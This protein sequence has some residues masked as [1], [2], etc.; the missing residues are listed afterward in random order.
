MPKLWND[1]IPAHKEAVRDA[2]LDAAAA[3]VAAHGLAG[4][5][6]SG[7]AT[8]TGIGRA[9]LYKYFPDVETILAAWHERQVTHHLAELSAIAARPAEPGARLAAVLEAY[10]VLSMGRSH[11]PAAANLH[12]GEPMQHAH[13]HLRGFVRDLIA[14]AAKAGA[15]RPDIAADELAGY[16]LATLEAAKGL[17]SK[18]AVGRLVTMVMDG[19]RARA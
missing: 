14:D 16:C 1:T 4:V 8:A 12:R 13:Q 5:T 10:G 9:T 3:L 19:M 17:T 11:T 2:T 18:A 15:V 6:M 7:I